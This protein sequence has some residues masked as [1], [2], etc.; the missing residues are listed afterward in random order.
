MLDLAD[1]CIYNHGMPKTSQHPDAVCACIASE[2]LAMRV[3]L[4]NRLVT[5]IYDT[6]LRRHGLRAA[7]LGILVA[8]NQVRTARSND[9]ERILC[10][11]KSTVS[12]NLS[13]MQQRGWIRVEPGDDARSRH[14]A[15]TPEGKAL[16]GAV[17]PAWE[18]AQRETARLLGRDG[19]GAVAKVVE[20]ARTKRAAS[21]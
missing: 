7:Q 6:A 16:L 15:L 5:G 14:V 11:E 10:L 18:D 1:S 20:T 2:C 3:R 13:R 4:L 8:I 17:K 19:A 21:R 12:R 9:L